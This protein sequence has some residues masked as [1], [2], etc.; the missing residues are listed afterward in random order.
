MSTVFLFIIIYYFNIPHYSCYNLSAC[1]HQVAMYRHTGEMPCEVWQGGGFTLEGEIIY[2][3]TLSGGRIC[4]Q[5]ILSPGG[6][7]RGEV[8]PCDTGSISREPFKCDARTVRQ[9]EG[10]S[11]SSTSYCFYVRQSLHFQY[12]CSCSKRTHC[13]RFVTQQNRHSVR[14]TGTATVYACHQTFPFFVQRSGQPDY[15]CGGWRT[16]NF[17]ILVGIAPPYLYVQFHYYSIPAC[18]FNIFH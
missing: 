11:N 17:E 8:L 3:D 6:N 18:M 7:F 5:D 15:V 2:Q 12:T 16:R 10:S 4:T 1:R 13:L 9:R 14:S